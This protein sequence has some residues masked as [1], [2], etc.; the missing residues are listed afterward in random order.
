MLDFE[1]AGKIAEAMGRS[2]GAS[3]LI[4]HHGRS[5][6]K[7]WQLKRNKQNLS[8]LIDD[9]QVKQ[10]ERDEQEGRLIRD[11]VF[12]ELGNKQTIADLVA[13]LALKDMEIMATARERD[14]Y[15]A[16]SDEY[17]DS[18][19]YWRKEARTAQKR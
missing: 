12:T 18:A 19:E 8:C 11:A 13:Q 16:L 5:A 17:M 7:T 2:V 4:A 10:K 14:Q 15:H 3:W 1:S 9:E 6:W